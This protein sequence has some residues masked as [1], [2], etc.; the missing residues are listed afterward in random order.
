[1]DSPTPPYPQAPVRTLDTSPA[2][3]PAPK[4]STPTSVASMLQVSKQI[5]TQSDRAFRIA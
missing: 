4:V 5:D 3:P 2:T 1:M